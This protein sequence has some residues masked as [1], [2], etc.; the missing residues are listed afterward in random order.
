MKGSLAAVAQSGHPPWPSLLRRSLLPRGALVS[1]PDFRSLSLVVS[2]SV[3]AFFVKIELW[4]NKTIDPCMLQNLSYI[5]QIVILVGQ[6]E[7][8]AVSELYVRKYAFDDE[9]MQASNI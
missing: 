4:K 9:A 7:R 1:R 5:W 8:Q 2:P 6:N 3:D